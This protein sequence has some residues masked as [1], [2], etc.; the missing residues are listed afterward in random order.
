M[1][2]RFPVGLR[3]G[4]PLDTM[5][6]N[7][8]K[9]LRRM[10]LYRSRTGSGRYGGVIW[11]QHIHIIIYLLRETRASAVRLLQEPKL[12]FQLRARRVC[13]WWKNDSSCI[14]FLQLSQSGVHITFLFTPEPASQFEE[15]Q[16]LWVLKTTS[17]LFYDCASPCYSLTEVNFSAAW[18]LVRWS[19]L[20]APS[21]TQVSVLWK[22]NVL[23]RGG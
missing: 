2:P 17:F 15:K 20:L 18:H 21:H 19:T 16:T 12:I 1:R 3:S 5:K 22:I 8:L 6:G 10:H 4:M 23:S 13:Y 11:C 7:S 14:I 9:K